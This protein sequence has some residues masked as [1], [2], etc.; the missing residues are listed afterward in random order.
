[1]GIKV[2]VTGNYAKTEQYLESF[3]NGIRFEN[4][5]KYGQAGVA[6]LQAATPLDTGET[7]ASWGYRIRKSK[8]TVTIEWT[9]SNVV[10]GVP[11]AV[12]LQYGHATRNGGYVQGRDYINPAIRSVFDQIAADV[13]KEVNGL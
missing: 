13:W 11:I 2:S 8:N 10:D 3:K 1:M 7:A 6:A 9:N 4:L 12:I 5:D